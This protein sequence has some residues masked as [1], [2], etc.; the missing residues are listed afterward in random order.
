[1]ATDVGGCLRRVLVVSSMKCRRNPRASAVSSVDESAGEK[2]PA[3]ANATSS[4]GV[5]DWTAAKL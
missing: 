1:M 2:S 5:A 4:A 3:C